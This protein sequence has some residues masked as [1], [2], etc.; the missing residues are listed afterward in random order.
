VFFARDGII[1]IAVNLLPNENVHAIPPCE[2]G[3]YFVFVLGNAARQIIR[4][5]DIEGAVAA[6]CEHIY[7][8]VRV[9]RHLDPLPSRRIIDAPLAGD[10]NS[11]D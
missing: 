4:Y 8:I 5:A 3:N 6:T 11:A 10:D 9:F 2:T 1:D 7:E